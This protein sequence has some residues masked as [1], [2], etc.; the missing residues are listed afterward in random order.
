ML[1][2]SQKLYKYEIIRHNV[3]NTIIFAELYALATLQK[4]KATLHVRN[5]GWI[6][7][8]TKRM[9]LKNSNNVHN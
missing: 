3:I 4:I 7:D 1:E 2:G 9:I 8:K 6:R 5:W